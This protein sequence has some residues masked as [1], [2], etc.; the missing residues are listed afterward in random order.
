MTFLQILSTP[1]F[2]ARWIHCNHGDI[3]SEER[4]NLQGDYVKPRTIYDTNVEEARHGQTGE[5]A[6]V[7]EQ[8]ER[9]KHFTRYGY[10]VM[11][12]EYRAV[13]A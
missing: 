2:F 4:S 5:S 10:A 11:L 7:Q 6:G 3:Q 12:L 9:I 8:R 13:H 1:L